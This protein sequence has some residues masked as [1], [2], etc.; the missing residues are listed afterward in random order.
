MGKEVT[1]R[2]VNELERD[3]FEAFLRARSISG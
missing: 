1:Y 2:G 3:L